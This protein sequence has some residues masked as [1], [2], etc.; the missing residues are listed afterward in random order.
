[1]VADFASAVA[2]G[3]TSMSTGVGSTGPYRHLEISTVGGSSPFFNVYICCDCE[4]TQKWGVEYIL[5]CPGFRS[6]PLLLPTT[7]GMG[8]TAT[9]WD[10]HMNAVRRVLVQIDATATRASFGPVALTGVFGVNPKTWID[11][12]NDK[13]T[14]GVDTTTLWLGASDGSFDSW[15]NNPTDGLLA[16]VPIPSIDM[17]PV[18]QAINSL[19]PYLNDIA[20]I[21]VEYTANNG[22]AVITLRGKVKT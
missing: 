19:I 8:D 7:C 9:A 6:Q 21:D 22:S 17:G 12:Y 14:V 16:S 5:S 1:M 18:V 15:P 3:A 13:I 4:A 11:V 10:D 20:L 2:T